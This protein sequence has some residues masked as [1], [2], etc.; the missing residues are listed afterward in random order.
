RGPFRVLM[1]AEP[2]GEKLRLVVRGW[3]FLGIPLPMFLA[4]GGDTYEEE[5]DGR[6]HFHVEIGGRLTGLV[7]RY[8]GWL[9]VE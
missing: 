8:T 1:G 3:R 6:F 5:R 7:V 9:V 2:D 4:P